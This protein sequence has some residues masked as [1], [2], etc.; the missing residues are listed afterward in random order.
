MDKRRLTARVS[1]TSQVEQRSAGEGG[2]MSELQPR[3][4]SLLSDDKGTVFED[5]MDKIMV[6]LWLA[7]VAM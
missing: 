5:D 6:Y 1:V 7:H 2:G 4:R 3:G